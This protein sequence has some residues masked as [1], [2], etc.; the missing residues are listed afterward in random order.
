MHNLQIP[1]SKTL[2]YNPASN[3]QIEKYND[4]IWSGVKLALKDQNLLISKW[5]AVS[6]RVLH[7]VRFLLC[8]ATNSTPH[9]HF[10]NFQQR[11]IFKISI[12]SWLCSPGTVLVQWY[13]RHNKYEPLVEEVDLIRATP[14]YAHIRFNNGRES[15][16]SLGDVA[17]VP[18]PGSFNQ[19]WHETIPPEPQELIHDGSPPSENAS[20]HHECDTLSPKLPDEEDKPL[21]REANMVIHQKLRMMRILNKLFSDNQKYAKDTGPIDL[22]QLILR[23]DE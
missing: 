5:E 3:G 12:P 4:I 19:S 20:T 15:N 22:L 21:R 14:Q 8:T 18:G 1:T 2:V 10:L 23:R 9:E 16:V 7:S 17:P 11:S 13:V 6:P